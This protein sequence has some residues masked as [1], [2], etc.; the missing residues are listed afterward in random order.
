M[1]MIEWMKARY[2]SDVF[3]MDFDK[4]QECEV[5][6]VKEASN[7]FGFVGRDGDMYAL[8]ADRF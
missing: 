2:I 8:P 5:F 6:R 4:G 1:K 7:L 3:S